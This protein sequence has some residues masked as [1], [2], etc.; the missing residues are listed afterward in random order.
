MKKRTAVLLFLLLL[1]CAVCSGCASG[2]ARPAQGETPPDTAKSSGLPQADRAEG[3]TAAEAPP[4]VPALTGGGRIE[5]AELAGLP[6]EAAAL[7]EQFFTSYYEA[8]AR[9]DD[10]ES[11]SGLFEEETEAAAAHAVL[12]YAVGIRSL[13]NTDLS[14]TSYQYTLHCRAADVSEEEGTI[15]LLILEDGIQN[16][17]AYPGVD[18]EYF[19]VPHTF[20]LAQAGEGWRIR[21]HMQWDTLFYM[22]VGVT[23]FT[24]DEPNA[25]EAY[26][27]QRVETLLRQAEENM[28]QQSEEEAVPFTVDHL[29]DREAAVEYADRWVLERNDDWA[30]YGRYGGNCQNYASQCLLAGG[31]PMDIY[32]TYVWKWYGDSPNN[33]PGARGRAASWSGVEEFMDYVRQNEGYGLAAQ[34]D[35]PFDSGEPGDL[36]HLGREDGWH[37]TVVIVR[38]ITAADGQVQDYL[39]DS[40]TADLRNWPVSTYHYTRQSLTKVLGWNDGN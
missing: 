40:N 12:A 6:E 32:G 19:N 8:L 11:F 27:R 5:G 36:I 20:T 29:Y 13:Q 34:A 16:F 22:A 37:H 10:D 25:T 3:H 2:A 38:T 39:V 9:L 33:S 15:S 14:L 21:S 18:S 30:D 23:N 4:T 24:R 17:A 35:A 28:A 31:I 1:L 7:L 26:Y